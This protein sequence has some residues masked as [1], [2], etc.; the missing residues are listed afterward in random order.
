MFV[1]VENLIVLFLAIIYHFVNLNVF[2]PNYRNNFMLSK[3]LYFKIVG[4]FGIKINRNVSILFERELWLLFV[5][6]WCSFHSTCFSS[7]VLKMVWNQNL[8]L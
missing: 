5:H 4:E 7:K 1:H 6:I 8:S 3:N 2:I